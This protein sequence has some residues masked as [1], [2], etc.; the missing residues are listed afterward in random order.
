MTVAKKLASSETYLET[1]TVERILSETFDVRRGT[2]SCHARRAKS[3]LV[4]PEV[5]DT[6]LFTAGPE[7]TFVLA[8]LRGAEGAPTRIAA[9]GD[10]HVEAHGGRVTVSSPEGVDL[11]S[12]GS[13]SMT[14]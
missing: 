12:G 13:V 14:S 8:V 1:G 9:A 10:L 6:V 7:G 3:C 11:V 5:G 4:A 2:A